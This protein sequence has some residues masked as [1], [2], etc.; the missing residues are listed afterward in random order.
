MLLATV[1]VHRMCV[2]VCV[3]DIVVFTL[4][5]S[6]RLSLAP[7]DLRVFG[8]QGAGEW[9]VAYRLCHEMTTRKEQRCTD[10]RVLPI[11]RERAVALWCVFRCLCVVCMVPRQGVDVGV[12]HY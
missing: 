6:V 11:H 10:C 8:N 5:K 7:E 9:L 3:C 1:I 4:K 2:R 12:G